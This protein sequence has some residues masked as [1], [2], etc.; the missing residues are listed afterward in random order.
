MV[1]KLQKEKLVTHKGREAEERRAQTDRQ[2]V[3]SSR[4]R[5]I[6]GPSSCLQAGNRWPLGPAIPNELYNGCCGCG[7]H[8]LQEGVSEQ[9]GPWRGSNRYDFFFFL[10]VRPGP[11][12]KRIQAVGSGGHERSL[13]HVV[14]APRL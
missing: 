11:L 7:C 3:D 1:R 6:A 2:T 5:D 14:P 13:S 4:H 12:R 10:E 8:S 9:V